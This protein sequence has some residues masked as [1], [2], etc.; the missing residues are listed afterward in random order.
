MNGWINITS[1]A[2]CLATASLLELGHCKFSALQASWLCVRI[3]IC[4]LGQ[5]REPTCKAGEGGEVPT[6]PCLLPV[7]VSLFSVKLLD[8]SSSSFFLQQ[9]ETQT[10][11]LITPAEPA[12]TRTSGFMTTRRYQHQCPLLRNREFQVLGSLLQ[13]FKFQSSLPLP[14]APWLLRV[15]TAPCNY[16]LHDLQAFFFCLFNFLIQG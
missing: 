6:P 4:Q 3:R 15:V 2:G 14:F 1:C 16:C 13:A 9:Q 10:A 8:F 7:P 11:V 5:Q 12:M